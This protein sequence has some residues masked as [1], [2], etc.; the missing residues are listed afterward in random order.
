VDL[1]ERYGVREN[2]AILGLS[3]VA[4]AAVLLGLAGL[5][6][7]GRQGMRILAVAAITLV[8]AIGWGAAAL[9]R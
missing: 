8:V 7:E 1:A 3:L 4:V 5:I 2:A 6:G 9:L